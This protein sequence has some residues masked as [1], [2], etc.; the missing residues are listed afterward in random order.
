MIKT[1]KVH[2]DVRDKKEFDRNNVLYRRKLA[3]RQNYI[4]PFCGKS[5]AENTKSC[6]THHR[7][8]RCHGGTGEYKNLWLVHT[9]CHIDYHRVYPAKGKLPTEIQLNDYIELRRR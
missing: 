8:P 2:F 3:K 4:C 7:I 1:K 9:A 6:E 5:L